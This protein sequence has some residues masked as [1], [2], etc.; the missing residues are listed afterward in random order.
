MNFL[1]PLIEKPEIGTALAL[2]PQYNKTQSVAKTASPKD[3]PIMS[4]RTIFE[5]IR[6]SLN[7][8]VKL[9]RESLMPSK[10]DMIGAANVGGNPTKEETGNSGGSKFEIP[11]PG[12]KVGLLLMLAGLT[13]LFKYG[14]QIA[15]ALEPILKFGKSFFDMLS[16]TGK[17]YLGMAGLAALLF[18]KAL[19]TL[20][21]GVGK[22]TITFAFTAMKTAF[23]LM[24]AFM[25]GEFIKKLGETYIGQGIM[26][27]FKAMKAAF[28]AMQVFLFTT[29]PTKIAESYIGI[30]IMKAFKVLKAAFVAMQVF[31]LTTLPA[32]IASSYIGV[33]FA[34]AIKVLKAAFVA[35]QFFLLSTMAP[36][37]TAMMAP[38]A[39]PLA[40]V[41][42]AVAAAVAIFVSI[43]AGIDEFKKSLA[44]GD[45]MLVA[46]VEGVTT[47]L[48]TLVTLPIT[49][50]KNFVAWVAE[51]LGFEGIAEK[52]KEFSI[53]DFIKNG[54]KTLV[55]KAVK[56]IQGLF[57]I[58]FMA[59]IGKFIDIGKKIGSILKGIAFGAVAALKAA[60]P[61]GE[62]PME[63]FKRVYA[64]STSGAE[65]VMPDESDDSDKINKEINK[66]ET[67][68]D[69]EL[70]KV[71]KESMGLKDGAIPGTT[72]ID[73]STVKGGDSI[74]QD[75]Y[76]QVDF[77]NDH[78]DPTA[79][80]G[81]APWLSNAAFK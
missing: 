20:V 74:T 65:I 33:G 29:V 57:D 53:V 32:N 79:L 11:K 43:K 22:G 15:K 8:L 38:F 76:N 50:I 4:L 37:L 71:T 48:L 18:P 61:G 30:G 55:L 64:E 7:T 5:D 34:K 3:S 78:T 54:I 80:I 81:Q 16:P 1:K 69:S 63:A 26:K 44:D 6:D 17:I 2:A 56:F 21:V 36:A 77:S 19:L 35:M 70:K 73:N 51:K 39:I 49:L 47:A 25:A 14:D 23:G 75:N 31:L 68:I 72:I 52:L 12:P 46:I 62:S 24:Q 66:I 27:A 42:L 45:S 13:L 41:V 40:A 60:F 10:D 67:D 28:L 59:V 9:T 58:D